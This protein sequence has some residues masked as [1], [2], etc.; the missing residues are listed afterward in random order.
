MKT[1]LKKIRLFLLVILMVW[2]GIEIFYRLMPN[3]YSVKEDNFQK[4][5]EDIEVLILGNSH[6]FYGLDP[7]FIN[8]KAFNLS[9]IS[10]TLYFDELLFNAKIS[11]FKKLKYLILCIEYTSLSQKEDTN[12]DVW[13]KYYYHHFMDMKVP[14]VSIFKPQTYSIAL[15]NN[16]KTSSRLIIRY[17]NEGSIVDCN[18]NGFGVNYLKKTALN[19]H[20]VAP[21]TIEKHEDNSLDFLEN[22]LRVQEIATSC[23]SSGIQLILVTMPVSNEYAQ[24]VNQRKLQKIFDTCNNLKS[25]NENVEYLNLFNDKRFSNE[26][27]YDADHLHSEG[28]EKCTKI[29]ND[30]LVRDF[31]SGLN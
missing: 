5:K 24:G 3:N 20:N 28:A 18:A 14:T 7:E 31:D 4:K 12:E 11:Q 23:K 29:L 19:I 16:L 10:Q 22:S 9:N 17:I 30:L 15:I 25:K 21:F 2:I 26:D 8:K 13:R 6:A 1:F 27:F